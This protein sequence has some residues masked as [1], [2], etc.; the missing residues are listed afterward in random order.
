VL[1]WLLTSNSELIG[2]IGMG[3]CWGCCDHAE[4]ELTVLRDIR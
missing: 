2:D 3:G 4:V 1:D